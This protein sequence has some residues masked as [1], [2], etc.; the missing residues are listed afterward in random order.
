MLWVNGCVICVL[1]P[2]TNMWE[3]L[4]I[5][6]GLQKEKV[7]LSISLLAERRRPTSYVLIHLLGSAS[8]TRVASK[9]TSH[10]LKNFH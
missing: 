1:R 8:L 5:R 2:L 9:L 6:S 4:T 7:A 10:T 3:Y